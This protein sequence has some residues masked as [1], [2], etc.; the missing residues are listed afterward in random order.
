M[1]TIHNH[2][3]SQAIQSKLNWPFF[4]YQITQDHARADLIW[5]QNTRTELLEGM[6]GELR[7]FTQEKEVWSG[8]RIAWNFS[9]FGKKNRFS[10]QQLPKK[11][12]FL[13]EMHQFFFRLRRDTAATPRGWGAIPIS[14]FWHSGILPLYL[15]LLGTLRAPS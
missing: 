3:L 4:F 8:Q 12:H 14:G 2:V 5:N 15:S 13:E 7:A 11:G 9:E 6:E 1:Q 10:P